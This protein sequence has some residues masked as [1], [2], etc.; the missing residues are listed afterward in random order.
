MITDAGDTLRDRDVSQAITIHEGEF[1]DAGDRITINGVRNHQ[2]ASGF[3]R[4]LGNGDFSASC[5]VS[6][7]ANISSVERK[8]T[9]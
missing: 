4:A 1:T 3:R 9:K 8:A 6:Q 2:Q 5:G 7:V